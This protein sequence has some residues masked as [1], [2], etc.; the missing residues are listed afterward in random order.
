MTRKYFVGDNFEDLYIE[1]LREIQD[2]PEFVCS[3]RGAKTNEITNLSFELTNPT[4]RFVWNKARAVNYEFAMKFWLWCVNGDTD[5]SYVSGSNVHA[6]EYIDQPKDPKAMPDNFS[7]AYGPRILKQMPSILA[8]LVRDKDSRRAVMHILNEDD[9][10][11]LGTDTK[12]EYPCADSFSWMIRDNELHM[13]THMR[14]N[15]MVL[16][17]CYDIFNMTMLHEYVWKALRKTYPDLRLGTYH[18][19]IVSAHY[20][21][22]EQP[23]VDE[24]LKAAENGEIGMIQKK[25]AK[26]A[27]KP[28]EQI[29]EE[30]KQQVLNEAFTKDNSLNVVAEL[31]VEPDSVDTASESKPFASRFKNSLTKFLGK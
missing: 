30:V 12:E 3:P 26:P 1:M 11:M 4:A 17:I 13:Y 25:A 6:K 28:L 2:A 14:S 24:V 19:N 16:T 20:Y 10:K 5:F 27:P 18:H 21:D 7:T 22:R 9:H 29:Q 31:A 15:A 8:E 23:L